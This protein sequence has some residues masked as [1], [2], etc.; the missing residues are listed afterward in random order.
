MAALV[1]VKVSITGFR[2]Y[3]TLAVLP[4]RREGAG[5][6][7]FDP[8]LPGFKVRREGIRRFPA[9]NSD[10][11]FLALRPSRQRNHILLTKLYPRCRTFGSQISG[12]LNR[13]SA[14]PR[15]CFRT[16]LFPT[17]AGN[18]D[19]PWALWH[20][21]GR[22]KIFRQLESIEI[23]FFY[24]LISHVMWGKHLLSQFKFR[25][26]LRSLKSTPS[27]LCS[28]LLIWDLPVALSLHLSSSSLCLT[29]LAHNGQQQNRQ[30]YPL[31]A[32]LYQHDGWS[33]PQTPFCLGLFRQF[34]RFPFRPHPH[35]CHLEPP[36]SDHRFPLLLHFSI[37]FLHHGSTARSKDVPFPKEHR[38]LDQCF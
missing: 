7:E 29:A 14:N 10:G 18:L 12:S 8:G 34:R 36:K 23:R 30:D 31:Q 2:Q 35:P 17:A 16:D 27:P 6:V 25:G 11:K 21:L 15:N 26:V 28:Y 5:R 19:H 33:P 20:L 24:Q 13:K 9:Y 32:H 38:R 37:L 1:A 4:S 3:Q 22:S